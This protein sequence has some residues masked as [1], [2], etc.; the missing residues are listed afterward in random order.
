MVRWWNC[1][2]P[3]H[4][5]SK[6]GRD[7]DRKLCRW[8]AA[9]TCKILECFPTSFLL[10]LFAHIVSYEFFFLFLPIKGGTQWE[11]GHALLVLLSSSSIFCHSTSHNNNSHQTDDGIDTVSS[12]LDRSD[13]SI[14]RRQ[15]QS[16]QAQ[17]IH[18]THHT[19]YN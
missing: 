7:S 11:I 8:S 1:S 4:H 16:C 6:Q 10:I 17:L 2:L 14:L 5:G 12:E 13:G 9:V 3:R 18:N 15:T 19:T